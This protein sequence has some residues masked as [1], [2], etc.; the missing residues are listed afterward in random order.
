MRNCSSGPQ[1]SFARSNH[2]QGRTTGVIQDP[3]AT[4]VRLGNTSKGTR[5]LNFADKRLKCPI[6]PNKMHW[7]LFVLIY[8]SAGRNSAGC[9][10]RSGIAHRFS[11]LGDEIQEGAAVFQGHV[12]VAIRFEVE[13]EEAFE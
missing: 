7:A 6:R 5:Q 4:A 2:D 10:Q 9:C 8:L 11:V 13:N 12:D 3:T 1:A